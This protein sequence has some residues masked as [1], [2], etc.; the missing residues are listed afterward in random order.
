M[1]LHGQFR[2]AAIEQGVPEDEVAEFD[3]FLRFAIRTSEQRDG[4]LVGQ[5][6]GQPRLPAGM[7]WLV[8]GSKALPFVASFD[9]AA[10][11]QVDDLPLPV[12]GSLL[13]FLDHEEAVEADSLQQAQS[14]AR[15]VHVP[16]GAELGSSDDSG[17][18]LF[19]TVQ[20]D[21][22][23]WLGMNEQDLSDHQRRQAQELPH[24]KQLY[25]LVAARWTMAQSGGIVLGG[26]SRTTG[27]LHGKNVY[28]T[29]E[30]DMA[31][32]NLKNRQPD[33]PWDLD[34]L[35]EELHRVQREW[36]PLAQVRADELHLGRFLV[37][38][39]DLAAGRLDRAVCFTEFLE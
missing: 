39:D 14:Y 11:P 2:S 34:R 38:R 30:S 10:L 37:R 21:L 5:R 8:T 19:A 13:F 23:H 4:V 24:R 35:E 6:S 12:D 9:C 25:A 29:P 7:E 20:A 31:L 27:G 3:R 16:A 1:D 33:L 28:S 17:D 22:P 26:Y 18:A 36:V 15:V 32:E